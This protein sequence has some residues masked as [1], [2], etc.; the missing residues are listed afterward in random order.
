M[1]AISIFQKLITMKQIWGALILLFI[2]YST[3]AQ[4][5]TYSLGIKAGINYSLGGYIEESGGSGQQFDAQGQIGYLGGVFAQA[6]FGKLFLRPEIT[7]S[8]LKTDYIL[9]LAS[10]QHEITKIDIPLLLGYNVFGPIDLLAGPVYSNIRTSDIITD[11]NGGAG[12]VAVQATPGVN[13]QAGLKFDLGRFE[14][15]LRYERTLTSANDLGTIVNFNPTHYDISS[16]SIEEPMM[17]KLMLS[18]GFKIFGNN[19][20]PNNTGWCY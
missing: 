15:D 13:L 8:A 20:E 5:F 14:V 3:S 4:E 9:P 19:F 17:N 1:F 7:Y 18:V 16:A 12:R 6:N 11:P 2:T 10:T